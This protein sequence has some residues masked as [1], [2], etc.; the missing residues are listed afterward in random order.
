MQAL[1]HWLL[2]Y[3]KV[4]YWGVALEK[5]IPAEFVVTAHA[6]KRYRERVSEITGDNLRKLVIKIFFT[7]QKLTAEQAKASED[8]PRGL[9]DFQYRQHAGMVYVFGHKPR[10]EYTQKYLVTLYKYRPQKNGI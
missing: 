2:V 1:L 3:F 7:A 9:V 8:M 6:R 10:G 4:R 5:E